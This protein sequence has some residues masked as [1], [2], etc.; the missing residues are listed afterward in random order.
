M[1]LCHVIGS[2]MS[3]DVTA[4]TGKSC[5]RV[6]LLSLFPFKTCLEEKMYLNSLPKEK[7]LEPR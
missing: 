6:L 2:I 5:L 3:F 4:G 1:L 7:R